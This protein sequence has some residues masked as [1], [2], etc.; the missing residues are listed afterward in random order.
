MTMQSPSLPE[1]RRPNRIALQDMGWCL[2]AN[3]LC[4]RQGT[5]RYFAAVSRLGDGVFWYLL[6]AALIAVDGID[7]LR[8]SLH[9]AATGVIA[10]ALYKLL[11]RWTRRP[12]P[13]ARDCSGV[14]PGGCRPCTFCRTLEQC[15]GQYARSARD[16]QAR[17]DPRRRPC[18]WAQRL[19]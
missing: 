3:R 12:R 15:A 18:F 16:S 9:L 14:E 19:S 4:A 10:L 8:A 1:P 13:F 17:V 5:L 11:K 6:M 2:R 7:G